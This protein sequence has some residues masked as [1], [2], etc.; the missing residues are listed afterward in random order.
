MQNQNS[1]ATKKVRI[2]LSALTRVEYSEVVEVPVSY[3]EDQMNDLANQ[4]YSTLDGGEFNADPDYWER[5]ST[6]C[7]LASADERASLI[8]VEGEIIEVATEC[9][10]EIK[11]AQVS[12]V[13]QKMPTQQVPVIVVEVSGGMVQAVKT[14]APIILYTLDSDIEGSSDYV[15]VLGEELLVGHWSIPNPDSAQVAECLAVDEVLS[16]QS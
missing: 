13:I 6:E 7:A 12:D 3:N 15:D 2:T 8:L 9:A 14:T 5:G 1:T 4:L 10:G 11:P 16:C